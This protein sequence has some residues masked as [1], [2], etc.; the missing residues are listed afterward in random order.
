M[1]YIYYDNNPLWVIQIYSRLLFHI[2]YYSNFRNLNA[3]IINIA[4]DIFSKRFFT[5]KLPYKRL[6]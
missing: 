4:K 1:M 5:N 6:S 2:C 3:T